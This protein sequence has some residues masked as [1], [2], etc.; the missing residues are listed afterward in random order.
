MKTNLQKLFLLAIILLTPNSVK[1][2]SSCSYSEQ[3]ELNDIV[4][5][6]KATYEV[7]EIY[8]G[9]LVDIDGVT[10]SE[11]GLVDYYVKGFDISILNITDDI[12]VKVSNDLDNNVIT[13]RYKDTENGSMKFRT[14]DVYNLKTYTIEVYSDKY[15]CAGELFRKF[16]LTTPI[17]NFFSEWPEC[18]GVT[19]F[20]YCQEFL[21]SSNISINEFKDKIK[22]YKKN[23]ETEIEKNHQDNNKNFFEKL[24]AFYQDNK[25]IINSIIIIIIV[26][27]VATTVILIKKKRSR[28]L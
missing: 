17:Y 2:I 22:E 15:S 12:Y 25:I 19:D 24:Q 20:Y 21:S 5:N 10:D 13:Y 9:K 7:V 3:A 23:E 26:A 18:N 27:G 8:A 4:A 11:D 1:A 14:E 28:V 16:T 6:V